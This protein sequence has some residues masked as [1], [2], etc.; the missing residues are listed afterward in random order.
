MAGPVSTRPPLTWSGS[1]GGSVSFR[2]PRAC[3]PSARGTERKTAVRASAIPPRPQRG[4]GAPIGPGRNR[5]SAAP[6]APGKAGPAFPGTLDP[7][8]RLAAD[9]RLEDRVY[10]VYVSPLR[11]LNND[12]EKTL[13]EPLHGIRAAAA[14]AGLRLPEGRVAVGA[15]ATLAAAPPA[16]ARRPPPIP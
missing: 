6:P 11:A 14:E 9:G 10:V 5:G 2:S 4:G 15:G 13:R 7:P 8:P 12:I 3:A 16:L 1:G